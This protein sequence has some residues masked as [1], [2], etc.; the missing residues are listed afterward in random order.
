MDTA[1]ELKKLILRQP[2]WSLAAAESLTGGHLQAQIT[3]VAGASEYFLGGL[4]TYT[5]VQKVKHL[6]V[7]RAHAARVDCVS[8]RVAVEMAL[9]ACEFFGADL[10]V[11]TTGYAQPNK[12][13]GV[14][15][16]F[17][18]WAICQRQ[19]GGQAAVWSGRVEV[20][21]AERTEV[22]ARVAATVLRELVAYL[23]A[24][25]SGA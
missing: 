20:P 4:T 24:A 3:S 9:G 13:R 16:P 7:S 12:A 10:G 15:V 2:R 21:D 22:Q 6:G 18:W 14:K 19:R 1:A 11:A 8:Q 17:A 25:R 23:R 5:L